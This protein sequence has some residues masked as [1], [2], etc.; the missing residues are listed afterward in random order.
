VT[1]RDLLEGTGERKGY[2]VETY[3]KRKKNQNAND[4]RSPMLY[5]RFKKAMDD[6]IKVRTF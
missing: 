2:E 6:D 3:D 4:D 5:L 1:Y